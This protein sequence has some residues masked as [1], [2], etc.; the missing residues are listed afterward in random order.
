MVSKFKLIFT[1]NCSFIDSSIGMADNICINFQ[2]K[3]HQAIEKDK[4]KQNINTT[5]P[6]RKKQIN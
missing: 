2:K 4:K 5:K 1:R 6:I 3:S